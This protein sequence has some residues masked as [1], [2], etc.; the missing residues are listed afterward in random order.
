MKNLREV[1]KNPEYVSGWLAKRYGIKCSVVGE[2]IL[3]IP[4]PPGRSMHEIRQY[5]L[6][7]RRA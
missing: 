6:L 2:G 5:P 1:V 3:E 7:A 4:I